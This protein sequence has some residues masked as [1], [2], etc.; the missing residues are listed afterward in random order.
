MFEPFFIAAAKLTVWE[1]VQAVPATAW[2]T[3][4]S[5]LA[6]LLVLARVWRTLAEINEVVPW[7]V[8]VVVGG[9]TALYWTYER[10]EPKVLTP[11]VDVLAHWL[12]TQ[13]AATPAVKR[14]LPE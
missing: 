3:L 10:N 7:V 9:T 4:A 11:V 6:V 12:P 2:L 1:K 13:D 14:E 8:F 5:S